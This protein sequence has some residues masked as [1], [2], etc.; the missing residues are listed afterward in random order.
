MEPAAATQKE[1]QLLTVTCVDTKSGEKRGKYFIVGK[2][3]YSLGQS[4]SG[5]TSHFKSKLS[6]ASQEAVLHRHLLLE[7]EKKKKDNIHT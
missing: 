5:N 4:G 2:Y 6:K 7:N 3:N 1:E